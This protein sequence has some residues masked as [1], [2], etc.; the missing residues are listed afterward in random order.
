M[1]ITRAGD[2]VSVLLLQR[3]TRLFY[4]KATAN[5]WIFTFLCLIFCYINFEI[6]N[7]DVLCVNVYNIASNKVHVEQTNGE[8]T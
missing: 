5:V 7:L 2:Q 4:A 3:K 8:T 6:D 1:D